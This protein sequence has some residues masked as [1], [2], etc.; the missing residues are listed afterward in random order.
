MVCAVGPDKVKSLL[1]ICRPE[2]KE[3]ARLMLR[4][5]DKELV[6]IEPIPNSNAYVWLPYNCT[7]VA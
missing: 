3:Q 4:H 5:L 1:E 2:M 6:R 7:F